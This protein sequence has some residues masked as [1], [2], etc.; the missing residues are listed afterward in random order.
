MYKTILLILFLGLFSCS[1]DNTEIWSLD[2]VTGGIHGGGHET[3]WDAL[4]LDDTY[5]EFHMDGNKI[6]DGNITKSLDEFDNEWWEFKFVNLDSGAMISFAGDPN[7]VA[8]FKDDSL[9][10]L[11]S[12]CC[13]RYNYHFKK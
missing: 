3:D 9:L 4:V 13:D 11:I 2:L 8:Q 12:G 6:A 7:K 5:F 1:G 10:S